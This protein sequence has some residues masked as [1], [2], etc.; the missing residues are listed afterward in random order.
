MFNLYINLPGRCQAVQGEGDP[1]PDQQRLR[2]A[3]LKVH[4]ANRRGGK[5]GR[6]V[7]RNKSTF[8]FA[9][10]HIFLISKSGTT[11][12]SRAPT[13]T[14]WSP[15]AA[16]SWPVSTGRG[17]GRSRRRTRV[18]LPNVGLIGHCS[19]LKLFPKAAP[20]APP[21]LMCSSPCSP[22]DRPDTS[23]CSKSGRRT[24][25]TSTHRFPYI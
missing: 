10:I 7:R 18:S 12:S 24:S 16:P 1:P 19:N 11:C 9:R 3:E 17:S 5:G 23:G 8:T 6:E 13:R 15:W 4:G 14:S 22:W 25:S 21:L 20:L 2:D